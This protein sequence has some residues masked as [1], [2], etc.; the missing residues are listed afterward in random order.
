MSSYSLV[1]LVACNSVQ[2]VHGQLLVNVPITLPLLFSEERDVWKPIG[3]RK[4]KT[5]KGQMNFGET[6]IP[7]LCVH[8]HG[9]DVGKTGFS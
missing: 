8:M 7:I 2:L 6:T 1:Q 3:I 5:V 4:P 9:Y